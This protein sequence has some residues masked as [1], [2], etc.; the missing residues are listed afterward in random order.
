MRK[1]KFFKFLNKMFNNTFVQISFYILGFLAFFAISGGF[2]E[3]N[4]FFSKLMDLIKSPETLS[5]FFVGCLSIIVAKLLNKIDGALEESMKIEDNHHKIIYHYSGYPNEVLPLSQNYFDKTGNYMHIKNVAD[6][7]VKNHYS[8]PFSADYQKM[9]KELDEF[10]AGRLALPTINLYANIL[11]N[12]NVRFDDKNKDGEIPSFI[13]KNS[14]NILNAHKHSKKTNNVTI[15]LR[16]IDMEDNTLVLHT[17]RSNYIRMLLT[18]RCMDYAL[19]NGMT[20]RELYEYDRFVTPLDKSKLSNQIGINGM[21]LTT[22]GYLLVEKR[23]NSK[24]TWKNKFAQPISLA[25]KENDVHLNANREIG[26]TP[27]DA[28]DSLF[29]VIKKT[30]KSNFGFTEN[31]YEPLTFANN[32]LGLARD[33]L[34]GGKPNLYFVVTMNYDSKKLLEVLRKTSAET[35]PKK[36]LKT[37]KLASDYYLIDFNDMKFGFQYQLKLLR[38]KIYK[39]DRLVYP[40]VSKRKERA[41]RFSY[42]FVKCFDKYLQHECGE[43]LLVTFAYLELC[44][45]RIPAIKDKGV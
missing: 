14:S 29:A 2:Q 16:D 13:I 23:D 15:R 39:V 41:K 1:K 45:N 5:I 27:E 6:Q 40:R 26:S 44:K 22:D 34:E 20:I 42:N 33:L 12:G 7:K 25:L 18:N 17:E 21:V 11:G 35:D 31:D 32:F 24:T 3:K 4:G 43:A 28:A 38:K 30:L 36:A 9:Q 8:D 37:E 19:D 10:K